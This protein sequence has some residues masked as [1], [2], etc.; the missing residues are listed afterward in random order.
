MATD[1][2]LQA[3]EVNADNTTE[4]PAQIQP[5]TV[6]TAV[7]IQSNPLLRSGDGSTKVTL[8]VVNKSNETLKFYWVDFNGIEQSFGDLTPNGT[9]TQGTSS[10]HAWRIKDASGNLLFEYVVKEQKTQTI[11]IGADMN[12]TTR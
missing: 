5:E 6:A 9:I 12:V 7:P 2:E 3:V 1:Q 4:P 11:E 8:E 10:T